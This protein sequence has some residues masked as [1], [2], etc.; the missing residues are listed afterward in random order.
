MMPQ[1]STLHG[2]NPNAK[3]IFIKA[4]FRVGNTWKHR[5]GG[6]EN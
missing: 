4:Q 5:L 3:K 2:L 6:I 1:M